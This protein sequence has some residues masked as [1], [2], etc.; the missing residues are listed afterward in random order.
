MSKILTEVQKYYLISSLQVQ[1]REYQST[2][3]LFNFSVT[4]T[5]LLE[6]KFTCIEPFSLAMIRARSVFFPKY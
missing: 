6:V 1:P 3:I 4:S 5:T 2:E